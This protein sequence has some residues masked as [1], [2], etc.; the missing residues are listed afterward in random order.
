M[1][2]KKWKVTGQL[3]GKHHHIRHSFFIKYFLLENMEGGRLWV[4]G[5]DLLAETSTKLL[6]SSSRQR[7]ERGAEGGKIN[8]DEIIKQDI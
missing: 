7:K 5:A 8:R 1:M 4:P 3:A 6:V 2:L